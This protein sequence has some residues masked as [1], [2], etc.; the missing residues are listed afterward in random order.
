MEMSRINW[1]GLYCSG[2]AMYRS[3]EEP[4]PG[5]TVTIRFRTRRADV[6]AVRIHF[7]ESGKS[8][9]MKRSM[10]T[11]YFDYY[12]CAVVVGKTPISYSFFIEK[13]EEQL[14]YNRLGVSEDMN[15]QFAF[16]II[17]GFHIPDW[18]KGAVMYQIFIDRFC[19]GD[20]E[21]NVVNDEYIYLGRRVVGV[22]SWDTPV[23]EFDVHRFYG[24]DLKGVW[25]KLDYLE[26]LGVEVIYFNPLF[27]S[28]S[29]HKYDT[30]DYEHID[31]HVGCIV[32]DGGAAVP[33]NVD[34][35]QL[36]TKY[37]L[38][39]TD[40]E[41]LKASDQFFCD[42]V[43]ECHRRGMRVIMDGVFNH[44]GSYNKWMNKSGFYNYR[45][46]QNQYAAGAYQ[47][48]NSPY[49]NYFSFYDEEDT[50]WP[51]NNSYEK[52]WGNDTLPKLNY[53]GS[54]TLCNEI[55]KIA[56]K[57]VS[58]PYCVDGWRLDVAADLGHSGEFNHLFWKRFRTAVK[59]A[60][61]K[62]VIL[63]EHYGDP[64]WWL[65]GDEWDTVMNYDAF[66]EPITW[67]L[68]GME[69]HSDSENEAL[70][71]DGKQFFNAMNYNMARMPENSLL[72]AMNQLSNH[73]H[74]RFMTRT[75]HT[76]GRIGTHGSDAADQNVNVA[77][78]RLGA[79]MQFTWPGA[80]TFY[81]GDEAGMTGW[82]EPD[83][84][85]P[86]PWGKENLD[87]IEF[88]HYL[89]YVHRHYE[90][91]RTG[92]VIRIMSGHNYV[93]Y[94]RM[95]AQE[96]AIIVINCGPDEFV[97][98]IPAWMTGITDDVKIT[99]M[100]KTDGIRYNAGQTS[101]Y[102]ENGLFRCQLQGYTGKIYYAD[103]RKHDIPEEKKQ[104]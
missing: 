57:W 88:H 7:H 90:V 98:Q 45:N 62:A 12:S 84:R 27:V 35:N 33:G 47:D 60:N 36:A 74:S 59:K 99:R 52:W 96:A 17:P 80:P 87:L 89:S 14:H 79:M 21:N 85:R 20:P 82:T 2:E 58:A 66:M 86:Y 103:L 81:Y 49:H 69:K 64:Y 46:D 71:G 1:D 56:K 78:Y 77:L 51:D 95:K 4:N 13:G 6:E 100:L 72:G 15:P 37:R 73:D 16:R 30:Q 11:E 75:N 23:E 91:F 54:I 104:D 70:R 39:T 65:Q 9:Y 67:F 3:P 31:P 92:S 29:N 101:R 5:D 48:K 94:G 19:D 18:L 25:D 44:C 93:V 28:P 61:P 63:A 50:A 34:D 8:S 55:L 22:S 38:R 24:G 32:K 68:T 76:V 53:E 41:N 40:P 42:F 43:R 10:Q 83:S 26:S 97:L 102:T